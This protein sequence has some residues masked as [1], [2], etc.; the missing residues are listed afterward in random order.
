MK[1][2]SN[3]DLPSQKSDFAYFYDMCA[4]HVYADIDAGKN[5]T[6]QRHMY[7]NE[8]IPYTFI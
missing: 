7:S 4:H 6:W 8:Y 3:F 5:L 2:Q 1:T